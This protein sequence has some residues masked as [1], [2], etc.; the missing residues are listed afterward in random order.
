MNIY[1]ESGYL[2]MN[3]IM[4]LKQPFIV[5]C[6]GRGTGKTYGALNYVVSRET[7]FILMRRKQAQLDMINKPEFSPFESLNRDN[8][9]SII[10]ATISKNMA[11]FYHGEP[12]EKGRIIPTGEPLGYTMALSTV[13][14]LRGFDASECKYLIF[15]EFI[16]ET[17]EMSMKNEFEALANAY[18]TINRNRELKGD[19][20]L[21]MVLLANTNSLQSKIL[22]GM[23]IAQRLYRMRNKRQEFSLVPD[24]GIAIINVLNSPISKRKGETALYKLTNGSAFAEMALSNEWAYDDL[25]DILSVKLDAKWVCKYY[26]DGLAIWRNRDNG[27]WHVSEHMNGTPDT[28]PTAKAFENAIAWLALPMQYGYMTFDNYGLKTRL[29][30]YLK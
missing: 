18:E 26:Y 7:K 14:N 2:D 25:S 9:W 3:K 20:P 8:G 10:P 13:S 4:S 30:S 27:R 29:T 12:D 1:L 21:K 28:F 17:H 6:G 19:E 23:G 11:G 22:E 15:D 24:R 16:P 5:V